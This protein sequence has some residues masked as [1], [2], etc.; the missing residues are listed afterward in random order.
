MR[1]L[2]YS[3]IKA[4][5]PGVLVLQDPRDAIVTFHAA[6]RI[7]PGLKIYDNSKSMR[8][9]SPAAVIH[10][11]LLNV[12]AFSHQPGSTALVRSCPNFTINKK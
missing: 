8:I 5:E 4:S 10:W 6:L 7:N 2:V 3:L 1:A 11:G 12:L 9:L